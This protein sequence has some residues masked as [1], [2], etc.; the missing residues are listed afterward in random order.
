[1]FAKHPQRSGVG[2]AP[3]TVRRGGEAI[4][5]DYWRSSF[6]VVVVPSAETS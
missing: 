6:T 1:L 5:F 2:I 4:A 3:E